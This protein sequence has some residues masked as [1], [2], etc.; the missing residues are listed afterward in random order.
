MCITQQFAGGAV[1]S[2]LNPFGLPGGTTPFTPKVQADLRARYDW[3]QKGL[4]WFVSAGGAYTGSMYNQPSTYPSGDGVA[5][6]GTTQLRY[7][8]KAYVTIDASVG[9]GKDNWVVSVFGK[10]LTDNNASTFTS[11]AQYVKAEVPLRPLT[12]GLKVDYS[13]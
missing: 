9:F 1:V 5:I 11:S 4:N 8:Q 12:Y 2:V 7:K 13:F 3:E 10:N 6:P